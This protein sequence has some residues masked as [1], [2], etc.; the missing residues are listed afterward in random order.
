MIV[1]AQEDIWPG[2]GQNGW[3]CKAIERNRYK[4][5]TSY[6]VKQMT[7]NQASSSQE[8]FA[9]LCYPLPPQDPTQQFFQAELPAPALTGCLL[10]R[11]GLGAAEGSCS[12]FSIDLGETCHTWAALWLV[13]PIKKNPQSIHMQSLSFPNHLNSLI[14]HPQ[15]SEILKQ[16]NSS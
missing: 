16:L 2:K 6:M 3:S 1:W 12:W 8:T 15:K 14:Q 7:M 9:A 4:G 5:N 10:R 13:V 11:I